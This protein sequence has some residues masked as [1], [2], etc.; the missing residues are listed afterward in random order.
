[1]VPGP[2]GH[3]HV[4]K[5]VASPDRFPEIGLIGHANCGKSALL[6]VLAGTPAENG[7]AGVNPRAGWTENLKW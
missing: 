5:D 7:V 3:I 2:A 4:L 1:M 6:N